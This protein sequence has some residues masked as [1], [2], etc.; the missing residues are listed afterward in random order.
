V[1][2]IYILGFWVVTPFSLVVFKSVS[3]SRGNNLLQ[4][5]WND[6]TCS[7]VIIHR[8]S[9]TYRLQLYVEA[10]LL[11]LMSEKCSPE[12]GALLMVAIEHVFLLQTS[13]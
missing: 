3:E 12:Y 10:T 2:W 13:M 7:N 4:E 8:P 11:T 5:V 1:A 6:Q 9:A